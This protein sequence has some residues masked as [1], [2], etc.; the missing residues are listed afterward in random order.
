MVDWDLIGQVG[1]GIPGEEDDG[2]SYYPRQ[3]KKRT[4]HYH[5]DVGADETDLNE[6]ERKMPREKPPRGA[7]LGDEPD[8]DYEN[9][10][11]TTWIFPEGTSCF[12]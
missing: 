8:E 7:W 2:P 4:R 3:R 6:V 12:D 10:P 1:P 9:T 11:D 5:L